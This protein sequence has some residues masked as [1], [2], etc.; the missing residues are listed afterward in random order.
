[1]PDN[2]TFVEKI[3]RELIRRT[4]GKLSESIERSVKRAIRL[5]AMAFGG[6]IIALLGLTFL[7][8]GIIKWLT[9]LMPGWLAWILVGII[10]LL[11][12]LTLTFA[13]VNR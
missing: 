1:M 5:A 7:T 11:A 4:I 6:V 8:V 2:E 13:S 10:I 3:V 9:L 12:G